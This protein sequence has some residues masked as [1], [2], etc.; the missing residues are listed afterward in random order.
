M[1]KQEAT[2]GVETE[3]TVDHHMPATI[4]RRGL[5]KKSIY[6][7]PALVALGSLMPVGTATASFPNEPLR[8]RPPGPQKDPPGSTG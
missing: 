2:Q 6:H 1:S 3:P 8:N 7:A 5:L 4:S